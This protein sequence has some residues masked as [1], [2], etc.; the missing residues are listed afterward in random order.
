MYNRSFDSFLALDA[1]YIQVNT[2]QSK[3]ECLFPDVVFFSQV[4]FVESTR[5]S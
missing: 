2:T 1:C 4:T 3:L 5:Q